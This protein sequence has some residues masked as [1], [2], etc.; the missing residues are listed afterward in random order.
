M[1]YNTHT[2]YTDVQTEEIIIESIR[3]KTY[4]QFTA[5]LTKLSQAIIDKMYINHCLYTALSYFL[6]KHSHC[7]QFTGKLITG[8]FYVWSERTNVVLHGQDYMMTLNL[9]QIEKYFA[10]FLKPAY[11]N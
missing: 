8:S 9:Q 7:E 1:A 6:C 11:L 3:Y 5:E 4:T 10:K 2:S